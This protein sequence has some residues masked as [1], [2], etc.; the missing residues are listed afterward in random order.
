MLNTFRVVFVTKT[1]EHT[2]SSLVTT[3]I[4][5]TVDSTLMIG[6]VVVK[7]ALLVTIRL[8]KRTPWHFRAYKVREHLQPELSG[9]SGFKFWC[10]IWKQ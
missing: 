7:W 6:V 1:G 5:V 10:I 9:N 3:C 4:P 2:N 8:D